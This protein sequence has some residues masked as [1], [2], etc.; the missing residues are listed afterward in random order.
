MAAS[1]SRTNVEV[2]NPEIRTSPASMVDMPS[3]TLDTFCTARHFT[4]A[5]IKVDVEGAEL[6][7]LQ[8]A[9]KLLMTAAP[10]ILCEIHPVQ[11]QNCGSTVDGLYVF[12]DEVC[13]H[14]QQIDEPN[15]MGIFHALLVHD[16]D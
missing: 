7:V 11:M 13:Y 1:L 10:A 2:L 9:R 8:G 4:P 5:V 15:P 3:V 16:S 6:L 14:L 12:L